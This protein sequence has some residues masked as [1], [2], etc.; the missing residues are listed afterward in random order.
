MLLQQFQQH[1]KE[2]FPHLSPAN[3]KFLLAVSGGIDSIV[4]TDLFYKSGY[5]FIIAHCNFLLR[6]EESFRDELFMTTLKE[7]YNKEVIIQQFNTRQYAEDN[8]ISIQEAARK[9]RYDWFKAISYQLSAISYTAIA[10][11]ADDNIETMLMY[12]FRGTGIRGLTGMQAYDK[13]RKIIRPLLFATRK[14]IAAYAEENNLERVED[15]SNLT[16]KYT[17]NFFRHK[18][19]PLAEEQFENARQNLLGNIQRFKDVATLY[20]QSIEMHKKKL[21]EQKSNEIH[22]P[23]L[24][25]QQTKPPDTVLWEIIKPYNFHAHQ[26][27]GI[28]KLFDADNSSYVQ[29][30]THRIIKDRKHF[31]IAPLETQEAKHILIEA[32]DKQ[33]KF[34]NGVLMFEKL[35][36][37]SY[38]LSAGSNMAQIDESKIKYPLLLRKWKQG[39]YFYPLGMKKKKKLSRF[40]IDLKLSATAKENIWLLEMN[41]KITWVIG[42]RIDERFKVTPSTQEVLKISFTA[43]QKS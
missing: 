41:K 7:K 29:S 43:A 22:I 5:D 25:L 8:K 4:L 12:L 19:I 1:L 30:Q 18:I 16:D 20:E 36:A 33:V 37:I 6:G 2:N 40:F 32:T 3:N 9:L 15:S 35:S 14:Q 10:H 34:E 26:L 13:E 11:N 38:Q 23:I 42:Y 39:D 28:K 17:R 24:K 31:I 21:I 27:P